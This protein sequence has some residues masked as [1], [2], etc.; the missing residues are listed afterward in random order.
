M[1][2]VVMAK[3]FV[4]R[5]FIVCFL[6]FAVQAQLSAQ[7]TV[8]RVDGTILDPSGSA[9]VGARV[10]ITSDSTN[11]VRK[12]ETTADGLYF[13]AA[14]PP[15]RYDLRVEREGFAAATAAIAVNT[16]QTTS[17]N[18]SLAV[19]QVEQTV[20]VS[21]EAAPLL[22]STEPLRAATRTQTEIASLPNIGRNIVNMIVLAPGVTPTFNPR[23]GGNLTT[24][25]IAQAGQMNANGGRS[26]ASAHQLDYTDAN[27][28]EYGGIAVGTQPT[29]DMLQEF[30]LLTGNW[31][32]EYGVKSSANVIMVTKSGSNNFHGT[33]Y[34]FLR[35]ARLNARDYFDTSGTATPLRQNF[36]GA[37]AG[38]PIIRDRAFIFAGFETRETRGAGST[39]VA[40]VPSQAARDTVRDP[41]VQQI[42][43]LLPLPT[44]TTV[45]PRLGTLP[46]VAPSPSSSTQVIIRGDHYFSAGNTFTARYFQNTGVGV[47]RASN[48]LPGFDATFDPVGRNAMLADTWVL[49]SGTTNEI[50]AAFGRSSALFTPETQPATPRF[51]VPGI[52]GFGTVQAWPQGRIFNVYQLNDLIS[53]IHGSHILKAGFDVRS[54]Q[55]NSVNDSNRRGIFSFASLDSFLAGTLSTYTQVF[56]NTYRGFRMKFSGLFLQDDWKV[57][58][59][60]TFNLGVR[61]ELQGGLSEVNHLQSV[62]DPG[63]PGSIGEAGT[64]PLGSFRNQSPAVHG[65]PDLVAPRL[66]FAWNPGRKSLVVRG[67]YGIYYD[68]FLFNGLQAGRTTPPTNYTG[69]LAGAQISGA[70][71]LAKLLAGTA[72]IQTDLTAQIGGFGT[73]QNL[74]S[75]TSTLPNLRNPY[76]QQFSLGVQRRLVPS[77]VLDMSYVGT[78][79]TALTTYGPGNSVANRP[80]PA[81]SLD[82]E[83]ARLKH[84]Q[85]AT[86]KQNGAGNT[87]L[88]P[89]FDDVNIIDSSGSSI[90]HSMQVELTKSMT[91]GLLFRAS[92]TWS[93]SIDNASDYSPGQAT[94]D[95]SFAQNQFNLRN[96]RAV[97]S[98][99]IPHRFVLSHVWQIPA[100]RAQKGLAGNA[101]GGWAF[102]SIDQLQSGIPYT[103]MSG[104]RLGISDVNQ[105]GNLSTIDNARASCISGGA[106]FTFGNPVTIPAPAARGVNGTLNSANFAYVQPLLGNDGTCGRNTRRMNRLVNFDWTFSKNVQLFENGP[107]GSGPWE[108]EFRADFF[109]VFNTPFLTASGG[110]F[111]NVS[112]PR[113][114]LYNSAGPGRKVQLALKLTW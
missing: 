40:S 52:V 54:V 114:G 43:K 42:L 37:S 82:D 48:S 97:S 99:D 5:L 69:R 109:N 62:L 88:D 73:R 104:P 105:D 33:A 32:A 106:D 50:R 34:D 89:R 75:L 112:T 96:D 30:K 100:F 60:L 76:V 36:Y 45:D 9:V 58:P 102:S 72:Q 59:S 31:A 49:G 81:I 8:G 14:I 84:F 19:G 21:G 51:P 108:A 90:Y 16:S 87:R 74:G 11:I 93:K 15:G 68:S 27:D 92:Y 113:F 28:W 4:S 20:T 10:Q 65:H 17:Q 47:N 71:N 35:N 110:D 111:S 25:S 86:A 98:F 61:W 79:G 22:S 53:H 41:S 7:F 77:L 78:K 24:L 70:N 1:L 2:V 83:R 101:L 55:D 12:F 13:F 56:G 107:A 23:G 18:F 39:F 6:L 26:K 44:A 94:T 80:A 91:A 57:T 103:M 29:P 63:T 38:A 46:V 95:H 3:M 64:G 67:G 66:G 85:A